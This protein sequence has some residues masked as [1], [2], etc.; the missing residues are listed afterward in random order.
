[1]R[2]IN[3][4]NKNNIKNKFTQALELPKEIVLNLPLITITGKEELTIENYKGIIEYSDDKLRINTSCG[5]VKIE[6]S[7]LTI[8]QITEENMFITGKI[9][10]FEYLL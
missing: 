6:G 3:K 9:T 2:K 8:K 1:M 10:R 5:V 7:K 4:I